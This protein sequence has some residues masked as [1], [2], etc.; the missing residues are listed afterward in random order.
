MNRRGLLTSL[1]GSGI[2][3]GTPF[4]FAQELRT[5]TVS[6]FEA[7]LSTFTKV[8]ERAGGQ[9][10][11]LYDTQG[12][13]LETLKKVATESVLMGRFEM[14]MYNGKYYKGSIDWTGNVPS[15]I[16]ISLEGLARKG[17][18][19]PQAFLERGRYRLEIG[20]IEGA[21]AD[22]KAAKKYFQEQKQKDSAGYERAESELNKL[23]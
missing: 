15:A 6:L 22:F 20:E 12:R 13:L 19:Y 9:E 5:T 11:D 18:P 10:I 3:I 2:A 14:D 23:P 21:R 4:V 1:V 7:D 17:K 16:V 8:V